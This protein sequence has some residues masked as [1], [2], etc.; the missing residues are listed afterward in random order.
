M[1]IPNH[2][3]VV[4]AARAKYAHLT[5]TERAYYI[6][7]Q[8]A[9][10]LRLE[11]AGSFFKNSGT[12]YNGPY[13]PRSIDI[14]IYKHRA[15]DPAGK[16]ATFDILGDA[17]GSAVPQWG[18][19]SPTGFGDVTVWRA[20]VEPEGEPEPPP[21]ANHEAVLRDVRGDLE[22]IQIELGKTIDKIDTAL[23]D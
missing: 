4:T 19:T 16:G 13:G 17:E 12:H 7:N 20:P 15:E 23:G 14:V 18:R 8:V 6:V 3:D 1:P 9:W 10:D 2:K 11:G 22:I 5:G 21:P